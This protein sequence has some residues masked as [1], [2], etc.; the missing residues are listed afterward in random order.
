MEYPAYYSPYD[1]ILIDVRARNDCLIESYKLL[2]SN[3]VVVSHDANRK[4]YQEGCSNFNNF[5]LFQDY[6]VDSGIWV[7]TKGIDLDVYFNTDKHKKIWKVND[8]MYR[9]I[10]SNLPIR[11][12]NLLR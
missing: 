8:K 3:G 12:R 10:M 11:L 2:N 5:I 4:Y 9:C 1:F 7:V 6:R